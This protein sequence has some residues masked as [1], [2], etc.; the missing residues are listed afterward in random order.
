MDICTNITLSHDDLGHALPLF[1]AVFPLLPRL[2]VFWW[3]AE[4]IFRAMDQDHSGSIN[5]TEFVAGCLVEKQVGEAALRTAF[6]R[7]DH[8]R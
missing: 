7:L 1:L 5:F 3:Q 4:E 6:D 8:S 2:C